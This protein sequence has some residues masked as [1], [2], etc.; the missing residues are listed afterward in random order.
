MKDTPPP[1]IGGK[2][3]EASDIELGKK[4][5]SEGLFLLLFLSPNQVMNRDFESILINQ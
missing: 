1:A 4:Q 2:I 5:S 3:F